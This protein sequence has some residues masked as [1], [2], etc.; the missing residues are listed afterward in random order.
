MKLY[1]ALQQRE[2]AGNPVRVGASGKGWMG[3]GFAAAMARVPGM[4][5]SVLA[6]RDAAQARRA[7]LESGVPAGKIREA[8]SEG[9]AAD[10]L[11]AGNRVFTADITLPARVPGLDIVTDVT[12]SP[13]I[14]AEVPLEVTHLGQLLT[15]LGRPVVTYAIFESVQ[16]SHD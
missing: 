1:H 5:L 9:K 4:Q 3:S 12:W 10:A 11:R 8:E 13:A 14:G 6:D 15:A 7:L 2:A 16:E